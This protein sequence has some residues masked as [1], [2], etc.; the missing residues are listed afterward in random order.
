[1]LFHVMMEFCL[2]LLRSKFWLIGEWSNGWSLL[3]CGMSYGNTQHYSPRRCA[4]WQH[5]RNTSPMWTV[6]NVQTIDNFRLKKPLYQTYPS[7]SHGQ[8]CCALWLASA[9][10]SVLIQERSG[11]LN[12]VYYNNGNAF[13]IG[14][15]V[16]IVHATFNK[17]LDLT[18]EYIS[19]TF[20]GRTVSNW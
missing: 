10:T 2:D 6:S 5:A 11:C 9:C 18:P 17:R 13:C 12:S 20:I 14:G 3:H 8:F 7:L 19:I 16:A 1:M 4:E 15:R